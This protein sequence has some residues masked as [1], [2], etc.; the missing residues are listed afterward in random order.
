MSLAV[1]FPG[2]IPTSYAA[3][4]HYVESDAYFRRRLEQA[5]EVLKLSLMERY[6]DSS[7]PQTDIERCVFLVITLA[8]A[9]WAD[10]HLRMQPAFC[11]AES[12]GGL[13]SAAYAESLTF[14]G[15]LELTYRG[16]HEEMRYLDELDGSYRT[17]FF[18]RLPLPRVERLVEEERARSGW[19]ELAVYLSENIYAVCTPEGAVDR[20]KKAVRREGGVAMHTMDRPV[21]SS[22]LRRLRE[23]TERKIYDRIPFRRA[24]MPLISDVDGSLAQEGPEVKKMLLDG[25][26]RPVSWLTAV[27]T[28]Q[29][30]GV[31]EVF[32]VGPRNIFGRMARKHLRVTEISPETVVTGNPKDR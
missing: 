8:L 15:A 25:I 22:V 18:Y 13:A 23:D 7:A 6:R 32:I 19:I 12:F 27:T 9:D 2:L 3:V 29:R 1:I 5:D 26:D 14:E 10:D 20:F 31:K 28:M 17:V 24:K 4:S 30:E 21:H 11:V 16:A